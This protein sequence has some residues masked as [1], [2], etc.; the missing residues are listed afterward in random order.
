MIFLDI[1]H[2]KSINDEHG[3]DAGDAV[4]RGVAQCLKDAVRATDG[5][6]RYGGEEFVV[7]IHNAPKGGAMTMA[8]RLRRAVESSCLRWGNLELRGTAGHR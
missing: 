5:V 6:F 3:H 4:L 2:F 1:D 8:E 7:L